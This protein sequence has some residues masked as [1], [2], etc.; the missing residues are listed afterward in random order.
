VSLALGV[1]M[2]RAPR[3]VATPSAVSQ[4]LFPTRSL[5][6]GCDQAVDYSRLALYDILDEAH[7]AHRPRQLRTWIDDT[8]HCELGREQ[9]VGTKLVQVA[10]TLVTMLQDRGL[11]VSPKTVVL[12]TP[13]RLGRS[14]VKRLAEVGIH[15]TATAAGRD[16]GLDTH[17]SRRS[18]R[19][20]QERLRRAGRRARGIRAVLH[21][22]RN[23]KKLVN[24]GFKPTAIWGIDGPGLAPTQIKRVKTLVAGMSAARYPG[25]CATVAIR[26][27]LGE[28]ADPALYGR[29]QLIREYLQLREE[30]LRDQKAA[31]SL[32]WR[33][34]VATLRGSKRPWA[35]AKGMISAVIATL[36][37]L[38]WEPTSP[39]TW[40]DSDGEV[41]HLDTVDPEYL[42][43]YV[44]KGA[45][46]EH[47]W[48]AAAQYHLGR[49][50]EHGIGFTTVHRHLRSLRRREMHGHA[51]LLQMVCTGALWPAARRFGTDDQGNLQEQFELQ[52]PNQTEDTGGID[53]EYEP[54]R[55]DASNLD[56]PE[57]ELDLD[58]EAHRGEYEQEEDQEDHSQGFDV[59]DQD[60]PEHFQRRAEHWTS[61]Q[62]PRCQEVP[63]T[64]FHQLWECPCNRDIP[65]ARL[66]LVDRARE[67]WRTHP[68]YWLRGLPPVLWTQRLCEQPVTATPQYEGL[69]PSNPLP[70]TEDMYIATDG[71]GGPHSAEV[72]LRRC[73]WGFAV[74]DSRGGQLGVARGPPARLE[75]NGSLDRA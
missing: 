4:L 11:K 8:S 51:G 68:C 10:E 44:L 1:L 49:G 18:T 64:S 60:Y 47:I 63:E 23:A 27:G 46:S 38:S 73:G 29:L 67:G 71:S 35:Q 14:V 13:P 3:R 36:L 57:M 32:A 7:R 56:N 25:S 72:R 45:V 75:T 74:L 28:A 55:T 33:K 5:I 26:I 41:L 19:A 20:Q 54:A 52:Q 9:D 24:T 16:L 61:V 17:G 50:A 30:F 53:V 31:L 37:E 22:D 2:H 40:A 66:D 59:Q 15:L 69:S 65:G 6:V 62:C 70:V 34:L 43:D 12:T 48:K 42:V 58:Q 39:S 21:V